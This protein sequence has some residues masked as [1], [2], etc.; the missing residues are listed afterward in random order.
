MNGRGA[1]S[2]LDSPGSINPQPSV[3]IGDGKAH[4]SAYF[5][6]HLILILC[7]DRSDFYTNF[8]ATDPPLHRDHRLHLGNFRAP[9]DGAA[10]Y[11]S[12]PWDRL[13][14][15]PVRVNRRSWLRVGGCSRP[16][17]GSSGCLGTI[18]ERSGTL[19]SAL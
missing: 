1:F 7:G 9:F 3:T 18:A 14:P 2:G 16:L 17:A 5:P 12:V 11:C 6:A 15:A 13:V 19:L 8:V 4:A 10:T